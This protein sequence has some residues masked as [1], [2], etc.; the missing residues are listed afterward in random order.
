M[1]NLKEYLGGRDALYPLTQEQ[2]DNAEDL[3]ERIAELED[4]W[5]DES[6]E[7][8]E[9]TSGYRP[10]AINATVPGAHHGDAHEDCQ[11]IDLHDP[12]LELTD[13][14]LRNTTLLEQIGLYLES[15]QSAKNHCHLQSRPPKSG[16][17][18]F[19]A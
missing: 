12:N 14:L 19:I 11:A 6:G 15:P 5:S 7:E 10:A 18:V 8:F 1:I 3:L 4:H 17:R 16:H 9:M 2:Y 13:F